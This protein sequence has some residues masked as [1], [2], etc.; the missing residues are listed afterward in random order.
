MDYADLF[1]VTLHDDNIQEFDT[2]WDEVLLS[3]SNVPSD[4]ILE[5][6]YKLRIRES[7]HLK[8]VL[9]SH[10]MD[11]HQ[12]MS[13]PNNQKLKTMVKKR[14]DQK[15][16]LRKFDGSHGR[17][18]AE[19]VTKSRKGLAGVH[20]GK[21]ICYQ[22]KEKSQCSQGDRCNFRHETQDRAQKPEHTAATTS[23][24]TTSRG[25]SVSKKRSIR[26]KR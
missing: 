18:E 16:R 5:S 21:G 19:A 8:T 20:G 9:E 14:K 12:K 6:L 25:R 4:D 11:I 2:R 22:W 24:P 26:G 1:S 10:D 17:I 7:D 13:V 3:M 23:E 15:L